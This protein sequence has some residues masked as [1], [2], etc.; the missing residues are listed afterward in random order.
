CKGDV[1]LGEFLIISFGNFSN[2]DFADI[3]QTMRIIFDK[4]KDC[5]LCEKYAAKIHRLYREYNLKSLPLSPELSEQLYSSWDRGKPTSLY[6]QLE[7][8]K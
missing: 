6:K 4:G 3:Y 8:L 2:D 5:F 1:L 7:K